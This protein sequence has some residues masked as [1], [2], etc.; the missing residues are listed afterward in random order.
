MHDPGLDVSRETQEKL[1]AYADLVRKWSP[2]INLVARGTLALLD[3]RHIADSIQV[4]RSST[5]ADGAWLDFGS[6]GGFPGIVVA[7]LLGETR[8]I[9]L[10]ESDA[11]KAAFLQTVRRELGIR[12]EIVTDRIENRSSIGASTISAR[13][14]ASLDRLFELAQP[15]LAPDGELILPKGRRW[16]DED[17]VA[18]RSWGYDCDV[19]P[20][21]TAPDSVLLRIRNLRHL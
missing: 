18:R 3:D 5:N 20:S 14:V 17:M 19:I 4:A 13:A 1:G 21:Q 7:I 8:P 10:V 16:R 12:A 11:R 6:G 2:K 15:H 9:I